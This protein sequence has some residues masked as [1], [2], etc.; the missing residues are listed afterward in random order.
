MTA[1]VTI[2][3]LI[4]AGTLLLLA[5]APPPDKPKEPP[6]CDPD[7]RYW[8]HIDKGEKAYCFDG[9]GFAASNAPAHVKGYFE[10]EASS[11]E[12][13]V[14]G[15][16]S[17][18]KNV[19]PAGNTA[20]TGLPSL[21]SGGSGGGGGGG[22]SIAGGGGA[23][24]G[25]KP[26]A[27]KDLEKMMNQGAQASYE[28]GAGGRGN[29]RRDGGPLPLEALRL[30]AVGMSRTQVQAKLGV[31]HGRIL[32]SGDEGNYEIWTYLTR[33]GNSASVRIREGRVISVRLP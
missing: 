20:F 11:P 22:Y 32:N 12:G 15:K 17:S 33:D 29:G 3:A 31:P 19:A 26:S 16:G 18:P 24:G 23:S 1:S 13:P 5:G 6:K 27:L 10:P 30:V 28:D 21:P 25:A 2:T 14:A 4:V 8:V 9:D 7:G